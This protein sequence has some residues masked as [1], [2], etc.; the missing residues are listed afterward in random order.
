[1]FRDAEMKIRSLDVRQQF[2]YNSMKENEEN[3]EK[4]RFS[5]IELIVKCANMH[6]FL[7]ILYSS[8]LNIFSNNIYV[9]Y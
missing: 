3:E 9:R 1:M 6:R 8:L 5:Y 4:T 7:N 2:S